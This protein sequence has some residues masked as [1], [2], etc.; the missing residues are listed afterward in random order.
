MNGLSK[1][2]HNHMPTRES[3]ERSRLLRP[4]AGRLMQSDVWRFNRRSVPRG[5]ALG[6]FVGVMIPLAHFVVVAFVALFVRANLPAA[7]A[8]TFIGFPVF[9]VFLVAAAYRIGE[10]LFHL[11]AAVPISPISETM[12]A[13]HTGDLLQRLTGAGLDTALGL[14]VIA[15][16]LASVGYLVASFV[17]RARVARKRRQ[18]LDAA[19]TR[20]AALQA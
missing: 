10:W 18:R 6:L 8:A 15:S 3:L 11:D 14:F 2:F 7:L 20:R 9:Y 13:T 5:V 19:R 17:W 16:V 12:Q 4:V 1:W